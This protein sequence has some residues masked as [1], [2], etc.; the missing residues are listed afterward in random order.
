MSQLH[1]AGSDRHC[2]TRQLAPEKPPLP[3]SA[4]PPWFASPVRFRG[5]TFIDRRVC[6]F[7][8]GQ[9]YRKVV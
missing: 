6:W 7:A 8:D 5:F 9:P 2:S 1:L 4:C 3:N